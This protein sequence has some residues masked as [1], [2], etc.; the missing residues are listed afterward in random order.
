M[1]KRILKKWYNRAIMNLK[2]EQEKLVD[3]RKQML[4]REKQLQCIHE[5]AIH[6]LTVERDQLRKIIFR[7]DKLKY[8][9]PLVIGH[10]FTTDSRMAFGCEELP[11]LSCVLEPYEFLSYQD[12]HIKDYI[13]RMYVESPTDR[14]TDEQRRVL[15]YIFRDVFSH[16]TN[17]E[18]RK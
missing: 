16:L 2:L 11:I 9:K 17:R 10:R 12:P 1:K 8:T 14:I 6:H 15:E 13:L 4:Q 3:V 7:N 5:R 18:K